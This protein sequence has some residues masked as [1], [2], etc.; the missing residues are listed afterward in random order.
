M[1]L[2][3]GEKSKEFN[4]RYEYDTC[5]PVPNAW[6]CY[7]PVTIRSSDAHTLITK[8]TAFTVNGSELPLRVKKTI[9]SD[10]SLAINPAHCAGDGSTKKRRYVHALGYGPR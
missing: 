6:S 4:A 3:V 2:Q 9:V 10:G 1:P 7:I 5:E 8:S